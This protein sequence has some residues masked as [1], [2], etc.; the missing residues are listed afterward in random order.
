M[1][2]LAEITPDVLRIVEQYN[3]HRERCVKWKKEH[4]EKNCAYSNKYY[5]QMKE[6]SPEKYQEYLE[7]QKEYYK[8]IK[9]TPE[10]VAKRKEYYQNVIKPRKNL[11]KQQPVVPII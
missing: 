6:E 1:N 8:N 5:H 3:K 7:K 2:T 10:N 4:P 9:T 11:L